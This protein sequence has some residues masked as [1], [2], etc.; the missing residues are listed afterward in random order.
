MRFTRLITAVIGIFASLALAAGLA[1]AEAQVSTA[2]ASLPKHEFR[3]LQVGGPVG[4]PFYVKGNVISS[5]NRTIVL[6]KQNSRGT[7]WY[8]IASKKTS[9]SGWFKF[10]FN[11]RIGNG[12]RLRVPATQW[13]ALT[14]KFVGR[15]QAART[16]RAADGSLLA[17]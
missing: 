12:F 3:N 17:P 7:R 1:P 15:I 8:N 14:Y 11:G 4:G 2:A 13:R 5:K 9:D 6:Q 16:A 10:S